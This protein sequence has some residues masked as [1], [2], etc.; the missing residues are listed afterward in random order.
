MSVALVTGGS[1]GIGRAIVEEFAA[2]GYKVAFTYAGNQEAA[3]SLAG[4]RDIALPGRRAGF[5]LR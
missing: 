3:Q 2:T 5:R 1:R 4:D